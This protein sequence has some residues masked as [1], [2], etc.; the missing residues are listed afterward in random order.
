MTA[1]SVQLMLKLM[2]LL[3][4][5]SS[6]LWTRVQAAARFCAFSSVTI[7]SGRRRSVCSYVSIHSHT[8]RII[9]KG[10]I[11]LYSIYSTARKLSSNI[12]N[13]TSDAAAA[14][15]AA[16]DI[17]IQTAL[18][19][20]VKALERKL[21]PEPEESALHLLSHSLDLSWE[22][23][24]RE[25][26]EI[27]R[28]PSTSN[29]MLANQLMSDEQSNTFQSLLGRRINLE[30]LQYIIG[31][32]DFHDLVGLKIK[33]PMLCPRPE[34]EE[35]VEFV[36]EEVSELIRNRGSTNERI[37]IL[38]VGCGTGA[39]GLAIA[40]RYRDE[41][42][43]LALDVLPEAVEL[44][45]DNAKRFLANHVGE[46]KGHKLNTIY[47]AILCSADDY[48][49][50]QEGEVYKMGFDIVVSNPPYIPTKDMTTLSEDVSRYESDKALCGGD[51]GLD[52]IR[53]IVKRL[54]EWTTGNC[55]L[56]VDDSHPSLIAD[57]LSPGSL[58]SARFGVEC[59]STYK[60]FCGRD[61]FVK[62]RVL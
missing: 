16:P 23:G 21:V 15:Q 55:W 57:W 19:D 22:N 45:N 33:E 8:R 34:T 1:Y 48:T 18:N 25:L 6:A 49:N 28:L 36:L 38:D 51:D 52:I 20:A 24:H 54:P 44:S 47:K 17:T 32:W 37:R 3:L 4:V 14:V 29:S 35:L 11:P 59:V 40:N 31:Q 5:S 46:K 61:R 39:I 2:F 30:P 41:V 12:G 7:M 9:P 60:D 62:L 27:L 26:R 10:I 43:V 50:T 58:E 53:H 56:E 42:Q 13:D